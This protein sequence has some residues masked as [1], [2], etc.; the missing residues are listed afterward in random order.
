MSE[1]P[2][3]DFADLPPIFMN[4]DITRTREMIRESM[5]NDMRDNSMKGNNKS[6][7]LT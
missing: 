1:Y 5:D 7:N 3:K 6:I 2:E 4:I